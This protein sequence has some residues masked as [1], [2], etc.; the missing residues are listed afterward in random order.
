MVFLVSITG[1]LWCWEEE[2]QD[3]FLS[4]RTIEKPSDEGIWLSPSRLIDSASKVFGDR[5]VTYIQFRGLNGSA[6]LSHYSENGQAMAYINPY[7]GEVLKL[8][9]GKTFFELVLDLHMNLLLGEV[10]RKIV[11]YSTIIFV[12]LLISGIIL[13]WPKNKKALKMATWFRW[14]P[15][16]KWKRKNY[17]LHNILGFY[18]SFIVIFIAITGLAFSFEWV[19][20]ALQFVLSGGDDFY[21][22]EYVKGKNDQEQTKNDSNHILNGAYNSSIED[23]KGKIERISIYNPLESESAI[24]IG[25]NPSSETY[26]KERYYYYD[27]LSGEQ[28][29]QTDQSTRN[30][31]GKAAYLYYDIHVGKVFG[32]PGQLLAFFASLISASLPITGFLFWQGRQRRGKRKPRRQIHPELTVS[33]DSDESFLESDRAMYPNQ[34]NK[35]SKFHLKSLK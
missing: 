31:G 35:P 33:K 22:W 17:D 9:E 24:R 29:K 26:F 13:W 34:K 1:S 10:G 6:I 32:L 12:V 28:I 8:I 7:T 11:A 5:Q 20:R 3:I 23:Y 19:N 4:Y 30:W 14:K 25:L 21:R 18:A 27:K 2:L 16:T 15:T